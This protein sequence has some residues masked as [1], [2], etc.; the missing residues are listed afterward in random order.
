MDIASAAGTGLGIQ[1]P[2]W[3]PSSVSLATL[4]G[5]VREAFGAV[6]GEKA[7]SGARSWRNWCLGLVEHKVVFVHVQKNRVDCAVAN[8]AVYS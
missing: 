8:F 5:A 6:D 1:L 4:A 7:V 3:T 2:D